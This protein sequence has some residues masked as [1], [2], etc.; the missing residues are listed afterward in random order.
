MVR[1]HGA[2]VAAATEVGRGILHATTEKLSKNYV[3][4][5]R[6]GHAAQNELA[7]DAPQRKWRRK[8]G[9]EER[10]ETNPPYT[11]YLPIARPWRLYW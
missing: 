7:R 8:G 6:Q 3:F 2:R 9:G 5:E 10:E 1:R 11:P 4:E